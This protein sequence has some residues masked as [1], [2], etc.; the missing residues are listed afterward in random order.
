MYFGLSYASFS[1]LITFLSL[2]YSL[3]IILLSMKSKSI[4]SIILM[5][6]FHHTLSNALSR[7][8]KAT[9]MGLLILSNFSIQ[10]LRQRVAC[11]VPLSL[12]N[13][14]GISFLIFYFLSFCELFLLKPLKHAILNLLFYVP[15]IFRPILLL[16]FGHHYQ[17]FILF[18]L[19]I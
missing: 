13:Q 6:L 4:F 10:C 11:L 14:I 1:P 3:C 15:R 7:S 12:L 9:Y 16:R 19:C 8:T 17:F 5:S 2:T 18:R